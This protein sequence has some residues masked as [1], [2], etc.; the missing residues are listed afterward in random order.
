[1][2]HENTKQV[3]E[4]YE[5]NLQTKVNNLNLK[6]KSELL[7]LSKPR[8]AFKNNNVGIKTFAHGEVYNFFVRFRYLWG[9]SKW[10]VLIGRDYE[11][12]EL[13]DV[14]ISGKTYKKYRIYTFCMFLLILIF[15]LF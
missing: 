10:Y 7:T 13:D 9:V 8:T 6:W 1:M 11:S 15:I 12:G 5:N 3:K 2:L 4:F 14:T